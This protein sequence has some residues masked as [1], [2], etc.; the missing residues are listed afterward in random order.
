MRYTNH[1][2]KLDVWGLEIAF[3]YIPYDTQTFELSY[4]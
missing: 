1:Y 4:F 3:E 2:T